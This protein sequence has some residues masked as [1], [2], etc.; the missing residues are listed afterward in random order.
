MVHIC[1]LEKLE[2]SFGKDK[3]FSFFVSSLP[4]VETDRRV[5]HISSDRSTIY[6]GRVHCSAYCLPDFLAARSPLGDD[7]LVLVSGL[8]LLVCRRVFSQ[9]ASLFAFK[10]STLVIS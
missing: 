8:H 10:L 4:V 5:P 7:F 2:F 3:S 9:E 6:A 1:V